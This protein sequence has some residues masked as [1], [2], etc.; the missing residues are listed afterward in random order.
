GGTRAEGLLDGGG[1]QRRGAHVDEGD[2]G[3]AVLDGGDADNGPV[4]SPAVELL[5]RPA[6]AGH[7]RHPDLGQELVGGERRLQ[8]SGEEGGGGDGAFAAGTAGHERPA[9]GQDDRREV[10]GRVAVGQGAADG[11]AVADLGVA[12]EAG[13][14]GQ[15]RHFGPEDVAVLDVVVAG[16]RPDGDVVTA[17]ADVGQI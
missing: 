16:Q 10:G 2:T 14:V 17:I 5:I 4:E 6:G 8:E 3:V 15:D 7:L 11:A 12:D 13:D 9:E 1:P